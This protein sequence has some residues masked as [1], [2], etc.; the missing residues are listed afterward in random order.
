MNLLDS[1][2]YLINL[3][4]KLVFHQERFPILLTTEWA[5]TFPKKAGVYI[6]RENDKILYIG[7]TGYLLGRMKDLV[8][9]RNHSFRRTLGEL[10]F[11]NEPTYYKATTSKKYSNEIELRLNEYI[12]QHLTVSTLEVPF[13]RKEVEEYLIEKHTNLLN[14]K[15]QRKKRLNNIINTTVK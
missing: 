13:G 8:D 12:T 15:S 7:E 3:S 6:I 2:K 11:S 14:I 10:K 9:T 5:S 1:Q 4:D